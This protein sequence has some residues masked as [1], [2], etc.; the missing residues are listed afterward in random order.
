MVSKGLFIQNGYS[1]N[2]ELQ[3]SSIT[4]DQIES[5]VKNNVFIDLKIVSKL[6][7]PFNFLKYLTEILKL[8]EV[9]NY[10]FLHF[11]YGSLLG[12]LGVFILH[13]N[14]ILYCTS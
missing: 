14:K 2:G 4:Q 9:H 7:K 10:N 3:V 8:K 5:L 13:R 1:K 11:Q 6:Y 12:F